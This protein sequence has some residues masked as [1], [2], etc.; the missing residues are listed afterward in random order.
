MLLHQGDDTK[1][2]NYGQDINRN[3]LVRAREYGNEIGQGINATTTQ[4]ELTL[5]YMPWHRIFLDLGLMVREKKSAEAARSLKTQMVTFAVRW[6]IA[7]RS[8]WY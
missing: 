6:N 7:S 1:D 8:M 4:A 3:Y 5:S 2:L